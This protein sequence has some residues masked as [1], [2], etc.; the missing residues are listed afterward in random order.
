MIAGKINRRKKIEYIDINLI[1]SGK[2]TVRKHFDQTKLERL[3]QSMK[4]FGVLQP[5][6]LRKFGTV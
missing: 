2:F 6:T 5:V 1:E 3:A 4:V